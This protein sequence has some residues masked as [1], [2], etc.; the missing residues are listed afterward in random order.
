MKDINLFVFTLLILIESFNK[1]DFKRNS[2]Q[3]CIKEDKLL[4]IALK[5]LRYKLKRND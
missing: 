1:E 5:T 2:L 4:K 3:K